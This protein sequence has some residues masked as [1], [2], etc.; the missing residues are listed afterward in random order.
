MPVTNAVAARLPG[1]N[2]PQ[3]AQRTN[4][5]TVSDTPLLQENVRQT[6]PQFLPVVQRHCRVKNFPGDFREFNGRAGIVL[7]SGYN[8]TQANLF[9][10]IRQRRTFAR[11][12][13]YLSAMYTVNGQPMGSILPGMGPFELNLQATYAIPAGI[14]APPGIFATLNCGLRQIAMSMANSTAP[15]SRPG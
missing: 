3:R 13:S 10:A 2:F 14:T 4:V 9:D 6:F 12:S 8:L 5:D 15:L 1:P 7:A 11:S